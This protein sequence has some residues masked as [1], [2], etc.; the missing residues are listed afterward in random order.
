MSWNGYFLP[1]PQAAYPGCGAAASP[2]GRFWA[3]PND[4][5]PLWKITVGRASLFPVNPAPG[6]PAA[7]ATRLASST[8]GERQL[9]E[10]Y[11]VTMI[12]PIRQG[13][14]AEENSNRTLRSGARP[15]SPGALLLGATGVHRPAAQS[16]VCPRI[17]RGYNDPSFMVR[18][19]S[20]H[21]RRCGSGFSKGGQG[22]LVN[23]LII[24]LNPPLRKGDLKYRII[25][26]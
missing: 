13:N 22:E 11:Y 4:V 16:V 1:F 18:K 8:P 19:R 2:G 20:P 23:R 3:G 24:P 7:A 21:L 26:V 12:A 6:K 9:G 10:L 17:N 14:H 15:P 25:I 5:A